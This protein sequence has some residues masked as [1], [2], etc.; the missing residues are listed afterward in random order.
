MANVRAILKEHRLE[1]TVGNMVL[2]G[3]WATLGPQDVE[4]YEAVTNDRGVLLKTITGDVYL[5]IRAY[6]AAYDLLRE[7]YRGLYQSKFFTPTPEQAVEAV[8][9]MARSENYR[10]L[11]I[12][13][14]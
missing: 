5:G 10:K 4:V 1:A 11:G 3:N 2:R 9:A 13:V 14:A 12:E 8:K 7:A 6:M